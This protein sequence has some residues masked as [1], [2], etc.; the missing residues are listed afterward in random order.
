MSCSR[1]EQLTSQS[2]VSFWAQK[3]TYSH[4]YYEHIADGSK[5]NWK[6]I[7][8]KSKFCLKLSTFPK[9]YVHL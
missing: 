8:E 5:K 1:E 6:K 7:H 3:Y 2:A 9:E 4:E